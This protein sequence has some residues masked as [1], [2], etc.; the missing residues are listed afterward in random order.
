[1]N[2]VR[3]GCIKS[4]IILFGLCIAAGAAQAADPAYPTRP[5]RMIVSFA[6]GGG[7][8]ASARI[9]AP[10]LS[11]SMGQYWVVDN[12]AG[13]AGNLASDI[14]AR[15]NPDGQT[16]LVALDTQLTANPSL[17]KLP[18][19]VEKDLKPVV[20]LAVSDQAIVVNPKVPAKTLK[21]FIALAKQKPGALRHGSA[22]VGSSNHLAAE[23]FKKVTGVNILHVPYKGAS[24]AAA[25]VLSG[26]IQMNVSSVASLIG[27]VKSGRLRALAT[28][29]LQRNKALP[30]VPTVAESGYPGFEAVQWYALVVPGKTPNYIVKRIYD[31]TVKAL[32][33]ADVQA[34]MDHLGMQQ[35][36]ST[37]EA[38]RA[39]IKRES[40][41]WSAIIKEADI[42]L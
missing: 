11:D 5:V 8:D 22:G 24:P 30:D 6:P 28:T 23:L 26:E 12:R 21:D 36:L 13:A 25:A 35:D 18:F 16:V 4:A 10:K 37:P 27:F 20:I 29:G 38:L 32:K 2:R 9:V 33:S 40:A 19:S 14:V 3:P 15:A 17:Y 34:T 42:R 39:R 31:D 7:V 1:M 41:Q